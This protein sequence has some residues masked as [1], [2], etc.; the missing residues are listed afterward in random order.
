MDICD[1]NGW[2][3]GTGQNRSIGC[4]SWN[5]SYSID[6]SHIF[7]P[8]RNRLWHGNLYEMIM[9]LTALTRSLRW[10][11]KYKCVEV[12]NLSCLESELLVWCWTISDKESAFQ[13]EDFCISGSRLLRC[14][15][16]LK[17][18]PGFWKLRLCSVFQKRVGAMLRLS[19]KV[20]LKNGQHN[21]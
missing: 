13:P 8:C 20:S 11:S 12:D 4:T 15:L 14:G 6:Q 10:C 3:I 16:G 18:K 1:R 21:S 9:Q 7:T 19:Q 17:W 2:N 5:L